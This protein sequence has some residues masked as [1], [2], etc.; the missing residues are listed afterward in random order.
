MWARA[1][2]ALN[3]RPAMR[4]MRMGLKNKQLGGVL[5]AYFRGAEV[6]G[7]TTNA[8]LSAFQAAPGNIG[9]GAF[10]AAAAGA[11]GMT[12]M[13]LGTGNDYF[14]GAAAAGSFY[15]AFKGLSRFPAL[16]GTAGRTVGRGALGLMAGSIAWQ[17]LRGPRMSDYA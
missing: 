9:L 15:G 3:L 1:A 7:L 2:A 5:G 13:N 4:M 12:A 16:T 8:T 17:G 11:A 14:A 10:R 6:P